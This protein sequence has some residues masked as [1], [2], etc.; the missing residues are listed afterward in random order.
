MPAMS[1]PT[2]SFALQFGGSG[3]SVVLAMDGQI[4]SD[5]AIWDIADILKVE[6]STIDDPGIVKFNG[7]LLERPI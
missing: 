5:Q 3:P 6:F 4:I 7:E 1:T 2:N